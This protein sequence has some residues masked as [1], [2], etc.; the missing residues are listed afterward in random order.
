MQ[1]T[2]ESIGVI[3]VA[4]TSVAVAF[5]TTRRPTRKPVDPAPSETPVVQGQ[6][7]LVDHVAARLAE[8]DERIAEKDVL[9]AELRED[10][11]RLERE[12]DAAHRRARLSAENASA[13]RG[14]LLELGVTRAELDQRAPWPRA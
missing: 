7:I 6:P 2:A 8:K 3:V 5:I 14:W 9:L 4:L 1:W 10:I 13:L 11:E 12:R